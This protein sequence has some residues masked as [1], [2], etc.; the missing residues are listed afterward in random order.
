MGAVGAVQAQ[1]TMGQYA[2][3]EKRIELLLD[4]IGQPRPGLK[5]DLGHKGLVFLNQLVEEVSSGRSRS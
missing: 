5:L 2:A 3:F 4:K 1:K